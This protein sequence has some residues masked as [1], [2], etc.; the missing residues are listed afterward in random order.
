MANASLLDEAT[1]AA[2]AMTLAA[3]PRAGPKLGWSSSTTPVFQTLDVVRTRAE[4]LGIEVIVA[5]LSA[6]TT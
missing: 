6:V 3:A 2:E 1:A 4:P 5:D